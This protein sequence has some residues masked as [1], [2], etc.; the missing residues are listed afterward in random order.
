MERA[1]MFI[2]WPSELAKGIEKVIAEECHCPAVWNY[3]TDGTQRGPIEPHE[4]L[5][6]KQRVDQLLLGQVDL[7]NERMRQLEGQLEVYLSKSVTRVV[8]ATAPRAEVVSTNAT[9]D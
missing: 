4:V 8:P 6:I 9:S 1:E 5:A 7:M 2:G 3:R